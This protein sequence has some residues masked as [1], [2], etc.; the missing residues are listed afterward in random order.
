MSK[1]LAAGLFLSLTSML[2]SNER[3][4]FIFSSLAE[5]SRLT[6]KNGVWRSTAR[7]YQALRD[8]GFDKDKIYVFYNDKKP[9]LTDYNIPLKSESDFHSLYDGKYEELEEVFREK[10]A[11]L[12][13]DDEVV[14]SIS[15]HGGDDGNFYP[16]YGYKP[17]GK[18]IARLINSTN[19]RVLAYYFGCN[20]SRMFEDIELNNAVI[21][22]NTPN[23]K[24]ALISRD[25]CGA[26]D[27]FSAFMKEK[28]DKNKDGKVSIEEAALYTKES[29]KQYIKT[30]FNYYLKFYWRKDK[31]FNSK[32]DL[33]KK[34]TTDPVIKR[35]IY[36][37]DGW[38]LE[39]KS[40]R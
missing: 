1:A 24:I 34:L 31:W 40:S 37:P 28:A 14:L 10:T 38:T 29:W 30:T 20:T 26:P 32:E 22:A 12:K 35:G 16:S 27:F 6:D 18:E 9:D 5:E 13:K 17:D 23:K 3:I 19:A 2:Y 33:E 25:Y 7:T 4:A 11:K 15:S 21:I 36:L 39:K 8:L